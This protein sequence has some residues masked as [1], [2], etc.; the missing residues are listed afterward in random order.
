ML[1]KMQKRRW[2]ESWC[3]LLPS[4]SVPL[5]GLWS[6]G[7]LLLQQLGLML[8]LIEHFLQFADLMMEFKSLLYLNLAEKD[9]AHRERRICWL[10]NRR[11]FG[12]ICNTQNFQLVLT[13]NAREK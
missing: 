8:C 7:T 10:F 6:V 4:I 11:G 1:L 13:F 9:E 2:K 3:G 5:A 12:N